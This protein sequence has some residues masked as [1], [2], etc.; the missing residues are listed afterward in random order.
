MPRDSE[1][2]A[3]QRSRTRND[4]LEAGIEL[5]G[6][7]RSPT[8]EEVAER[9]RVSRATAY[10]YF[11][12]VHA[13]L[14]E[15]SLHLAFPDYRTLFANDRDLG[16]LDRLYRVD[17]AVDR[18]IQANE[19]SLRMMLVSA[20]K[21]ALAQSE[22]PARQNRRTPLIDAALAPVADQFEP[23][24]LDRLKKALGLVIGTEAL[25]AFKDVLRLDCREARE[26]RRWMIRT[27]LEAAKS[28]T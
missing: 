23:E 6:E 8:L 9:A 21:Q 26:V 3:N 11:P 2:R 7:G 28:R 4:L 15:A 22:V 16:A 17:D 12:N 27:L 10:R 13:L 19:A 24:A 20:T 18:M 25:L 1:G 14:A 5:S